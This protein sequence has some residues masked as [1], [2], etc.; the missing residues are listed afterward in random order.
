MPRNAR[1]ARTLK[2]GHSVTRS[3]TFS[4]YNVEQKPLY[5]II[6]LVLRCGGEGTIEVVEN[7]QRDKNQ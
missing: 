1:A 7:L 3:V 6:K 4:K 2:L 5:V